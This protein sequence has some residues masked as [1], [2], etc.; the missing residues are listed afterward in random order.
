MDQPKDPDLPRPVSDDAQPPQPTEAEAEVTVPSEFGEEEATAPEAD[1]TEAAAP[2]QP[3]PEEAPAAQPEA[4]STPPPLEPAEGATPPPPEPGAEQAPPQKAT[5]W[6]W[7]IGIGC[8][9]GCLVMA[10]A[11][12]LPILLGY[13]A[14]KA[15]MDEQNSSSTTIEGTQVEPIPDADDTDFTNAVPDIDLE[16]PGLAAAV[17]FGQSR[18]PAWSVQVATHADNWKTVHLV[19]GP[20]GSKFTTWMDIKW[21]EDAEEYRLVD[22]GPLGVEDTGTD[23][24]VPE[25]YQPGEQVAKEAAL[26]GTPD[27]VAKVVSH[28]SDWKSAVVWTGPPQSEWVFEAKLQWNASLDCYDVI[29]HTAIEADYP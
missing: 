24:K 7:I 20:I 25:I 9:C 16:G 12:G 3:E 17:M 5:P 2:S 22:E 21:D 1:E 14:S 26:I 10:L 23:S 19:L 15:D 28:S 27:W 13:L 29:S 18:K 11:I 6:G 4:P 8:G